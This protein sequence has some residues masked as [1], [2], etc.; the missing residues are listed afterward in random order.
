MFFNV[1][2]DVVWFVAVYVA[3]YKGVDYVFREYAQAVKVLFD[4]NV[5]LFNYTKELGADERHDLLFTCS[6]AVSFVILTINPV[7]HSILYI[8]F[9]FM[10]D[11]VDL[12]RI[13]LYILLFKLAK[14]VNPFARHVSAVDP[15]IVVQTLLVIVNYHNTSIAV[16]VLFQIIDE[17]TNFNFY[18]R[19]M[20]RAHDLLFGGDTW[21]KEKILHVTV[22][23][24]ARRRA[25]INTKIGVLSVVAFTSFLYSQLA[26]WGEVGFYYYALARIA[27]VY[28]YDKVDKEA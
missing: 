25:I 19:D 27:H 9:M 21:I 18:C 23:L 10:V 7:L 2:Y 4:I 13:L 16:P 3:F 28:R 20:L 1:L 8:T 12:N 26:T 14:K 17:S 6:T 11:V 15:Q 24:E 22:I 5:R